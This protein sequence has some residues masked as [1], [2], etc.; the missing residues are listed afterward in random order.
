MLIGKQ[1]TLDL[2]SNMSSLPIIVLITVFV[3]ILAGSYP[4][5]FMSSFKPVA[6]LKGKINSN[7]NI[8]IQV[9]LFIP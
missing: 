1:L 2:F 3:G 6:V 9:L 5:F 7:N 8:L 4:A